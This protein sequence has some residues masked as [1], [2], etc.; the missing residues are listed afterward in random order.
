MTNNPSKIEGIRAAG[1]RV[2]EQVPH[3]VEGSEHSAAYLETKRVKLG[4]IHP[5]DDGGVGG[6]NGGAE[7]DAMPEPV[8]AAGED[9]KRK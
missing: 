7:R 9:A 4:H 8:R 3:W 5:D 2:V 6:D 1:I